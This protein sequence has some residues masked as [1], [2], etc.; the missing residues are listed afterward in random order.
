MAVFWLGCPTPA[1]LT[2]NEPLSLESDIAKK[3]KLSFS[4][5]LADFAAGPPKPMALYDENNAEVILDDS[6]VEVVENVDE[7]A[8]SNLETTTVGNNRNSHAVYFP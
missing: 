2:D 6:Q 8:L 1:A 3:K 5:D 7:V 4:A